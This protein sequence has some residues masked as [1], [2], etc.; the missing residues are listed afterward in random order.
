MSHV[1]VSLVAL[2]ASTNAS[3]SQQ[4]LAL[5]APGRSVLP[6]T[7]AMPFR[8]QARSGE[9][10][11]A[12][13]GTTPFV[14]A[15]ARLPDAAAP[16]G[17]AGTRPAPE[18]QVDE[19]A[20]RYYASQNDI[21]RV[22]VEIRR[23]QSLHPGW[24]PPADLMSGAASSTHDEQPLWDLYGA[25]KYAE[26]QAKIA[27]IQ[28]DDPDWQPS[29]DLAA[30][31]KTAL[32]RTQLVAAYDAKQWGDVIDIAAQN[33]G[34]LVCADVDVVWRL[35]EALARADDKDRA[36]EAYRY[37]LK[38]C[39]NR[40]ERLATV[41]KAD[42][43]LEPAAVD[44]LMALGQRKP[45][46]T[47]EFE[48]VKSDRLRRKIG[49]AIADATAPQPS[50]AELDTLTRQAQQ[51]NSNSDAQLLGWYWYS[52]KDYAAAQTWFTKSLAS[53]SDAKSAEGLALSLRAAGKLDE[54][55][56]TAFTWRAAGPQ[57][58]KLFI[59][60]VS[61]QITASPPAV[62][63][64]ERRGRFEQIVQ[65]EK[66]PLGAQAL[67]WYLYNTADTKAAQVWFDRSVSWKPTEEGVVGLVVAAQKNRDM[68]TYR[69]A[70]QKYRASFQRIAELEKLDQL[71]ENQRP[72][73][74]GPVMVARRGPHGRYVR[75][76][77]HV[78]GGASNEALALF[79]SG[80]YGEALAALDRMSG[81]RGTEDP[82]MRVLRGWALYQSGDWERAKAVFAEAAHARPSEASKGLAVIEAREQPRFRQ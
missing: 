1:V 68:A 10:S 53:A 64:P 51:S 5:L 52:H 4:P 66:S 15:P 50:P 9:A 59:E 73:S 71:A 76:V 46:G 49:A 45:D 26:V 35:A 27:D 19:S 48:V 62:L 31:L 47:S 25:G 69:L 77:A 67:G 57:M 82:G 6:G 2:I 14:L 60:I 7:S 81:R 74:R 13:E 16:S 63:S 41:Q 42:A 70:I 30:K 44:S 23:L 21:A 22:S 33:N 18:K 32:A 8:V 40:G 80:K 29:A 61:A 39:T 75:M 38:N 37:V 28:T 20:L 72:P 12:V 65:D 78:N 56:T 54:A 3:R 43:L 79:H 58:R 36:F 55:E 24:Q 11:A 17:A 34:L